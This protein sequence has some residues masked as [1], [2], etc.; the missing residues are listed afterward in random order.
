MPVMRESEEV[1]GGWVIG[2]VVTKDEAIAHPVM[3]A[4]LDDGKCWLSD[5]ELFE[6]EL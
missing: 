5:E 1:P 6:V 3:V 4:V 2:V